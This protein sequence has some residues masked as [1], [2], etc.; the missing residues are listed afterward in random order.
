M[1][2]VRKYQVILGCDPCGIAWVSP[3][4]EQSLETVF[5]MNKRALCPE[6]GA[7]AL[8]DSPE[9]QIP[10]TVLKIIDLNNEFAI[11]TQF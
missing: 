1:K 7:T 2:T 10:P 11:I 8:H 6:C 4:I 3:E 9:L 5:A